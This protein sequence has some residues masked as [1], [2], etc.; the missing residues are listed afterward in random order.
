MNLV[1]LPFGINVLR[2]DAPSSMAIATCV[3]AQF[4][5]VNV[6]TGQL[7]RELI[8]QARSYATGEWAVMSKS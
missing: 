4:I 2:N 3:K 8:R 7:I 6:L 5:R 1:T